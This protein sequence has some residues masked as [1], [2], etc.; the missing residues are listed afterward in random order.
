MTGQSLHQYQINMKLD[1]AYRA[2]RDGAGSVKSVSERFGFCDPYYFS[3]MFKKKF[4]FPPKQ[5]K[6]TMPGANINRPPVK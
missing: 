5:I 6:G 1:S 2:L 4:G 3:K